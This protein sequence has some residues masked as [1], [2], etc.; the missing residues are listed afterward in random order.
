MGYRGQTIHDSKLLIEFL[1][2]HI[3]EPMAIVNDDNPW[4]TKPINDG[5]LDEVVDFSFGDAS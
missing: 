5:F 1:K 2:L 3:I 4:E